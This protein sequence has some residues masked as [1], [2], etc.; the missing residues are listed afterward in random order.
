MENKDDKLNKTSSSKTK[1]NITNDTTNTFFYYN[2]IEIKIGDPIS[3]LFL[4]D[5]YIIIGT[6]MGKI[7]LLCYNSENENIF[8]LSQINKENISGISFEEESN[9]LFVSIGD[10]EILSYNLNNP[11]SDNLISEQ[12]HI[13]D[14]L[15]E[16]DKYCDNAYVL[17]SKDNLLKVNLFIP[18]L[19]ETIKN[20]VYFKYQIINFKDNKSINNESRNNGSIK[21]TNYFVPLDYDGSYFCW[22]EYL[23]DK[24]DRNLCVHPLT[25][26]E[27][28]DNVKYKFNIDKNYGHI[29]HAKIFNEKIIIVH[30]LNKC[31]IRIF[32]KEFELIESFTHIGDEVYAIDI[33]LH[34]QSMISNEDSNDNNFNVKDGN[35]EIKVKNKFYESYTN[36]ENAIKLFDQNFDIKH[37]YKGSK[38]PKIDYNRN[39]KFKIASSNDLKSDSLKLLNNKFKKKKN[40]EVNQILSIITLDIDGNVNKYENRL[41]EKLFNLYDIKGISKDHKDK[42]FFNMGYVYY[43]KTD[44]NYFCITTDF[45]CYIIK[46]NEQ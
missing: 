5:K 20:D 34:E 7:Q 16:H 10:E 19:E 46:R 2:Y 1:S 36:N 23:N 8:L 24:E 40:K 30:E 35:I 38:L 11:I 31:E 33:L 3:S 22:V 26:I 29:S 6:M 9:L 32:E 28:I 17:M 27:K 39:K 42:K 25:K 12:I 14:S 37:S 18:Q 21:S 13:Y 41:E 45:G 43:I 44:L 15:R 4:N